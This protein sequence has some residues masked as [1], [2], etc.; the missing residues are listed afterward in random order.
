VRSKSH[1]PTLASCSDCFKRLTVTLAVANSPF[2]SCNLNRWL[3]AR[4]NLVAISCSFWTCAVG[5]AASHVCVVEQLELANGWQLGLFAL[6][7]L[8]PAIAS[9][10]GNKGRDFLVVVRR[11][12]A[13]TPVFRLTAAGT[14]VQCE[15]GLDAKAA[16]WKD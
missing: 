3:S 15:A 14:L 5:G 8:T 7:F 1:W 2:R 9:L 12:W 16:P 4:P 6:R 10:T 13:F 11:D